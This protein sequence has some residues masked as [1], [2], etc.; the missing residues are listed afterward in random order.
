MMPAISLRDSLKS[1]G[2]NGNFLSGQLEIAHLV[3]SSKRCVSSAAYLSHSALLAIHALLFR[4]AAC[5]L[6]KLDGRNGGW[7]GQPSDQNYPRSPPSYE[8][9]ELTH[10]NGIPFECSSEGEAHGT[11]NQAL[12]E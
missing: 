9:A 6:Y 12:A 3:S 7:F 8:N 11:G 1:D 4:I 2:S 5:H 10:G